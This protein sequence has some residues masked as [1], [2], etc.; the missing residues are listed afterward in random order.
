MIHIEYGPVHSRVSSS[1]AAEMHLADTLLCKAFTYEVPNYI[2]T[3]GYQ[4]G[5][6]DGRKTFYDLGKHQFLSGLLSMVVKQLRQDEFEVVVNGY[7]A[8]HKN[9]VKLAFGPIR[10]HGDIT[11]RDYQM[12]AVFQTLR[13]SRGIWKLATNAGKTEV[14]AGVID[15][16]DKPQTV[17]LVP[18]L[19]IFRQTIKRLQARLSDP[20]G[21]VGDGIWDPHV[22]GTTVVMYHTLRK[23]LKDSKAIKWLRDTIALFG[24]EVQFL[25]DE[26]YQ[27]SWNAIPAPIRIGMSG[28][29]FKE[30]IIDEMVVRAHCGPVLCN[31]GNAELIARGV[32]VK[33]KIVFLEPAVPLN[34]KKV[35]ELGTWDTTLY[36]CK[37]RNELIGNLACGFVK[38]GRQTVIMVNRVEH[39]KQIQKYTPGS[40]LTHSQASNRKQVEARLRSGEVFCCICTSIFDTGMSVDYLQALILAGGGNASHTLLQRLGR[41]LRTASDLEKDVWCVEFWDTFNKITRSHSR[42]R[43]EIFKAEKAFDMLEGPTSLPEDVYTEVFEGAGAASNI[44]RK[45]QK[46]KWRQ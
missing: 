22:G 10:L 43:W 32:S 20:I 44:V 15:A 37:Y 13:Y 24:D 4:E 26:G 6:W 8:S 33:P 19:E 17:V 29:P 28:T 1:D 14:I 11:L 42:D 31:I 23:K 30:S 21:A 39:G 16:L 3:T 34:E 18:R 7:P 38:T 12:H 27:K 5:W 46:A 40:V 45:S 41:L 9:L 2:F 36:N 35:M 25:T